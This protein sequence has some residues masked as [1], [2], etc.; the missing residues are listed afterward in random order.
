METVD[1]V[2]QFLVC[3]SKMEST[4]R[5]DMSVCS[6]VC[7]RDTPN[8]QVVRQNC[9]ISVSPPSLLLDTGTGGGGGDRNCTHI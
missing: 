2:V 8:M 5:T 9:G 4:V 6:S 7:Q 3:L 1:C